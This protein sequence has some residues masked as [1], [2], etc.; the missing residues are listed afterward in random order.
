MVPVSLGDPSGAKGPGDVGVRS[1]VLGLERAV[2]RAGIEEFGGAVDGA[3]AVARAGVQP[4]HRRQ[5]RAEGCVLGGSVVVASAEIGVGAA[6]GGSEAGAG[7]GG[8]GSLGVA[9]SCARKDVTVSVTEVEP[10]A[11]AGHE[12]G[13]KR[14]AADM[15]QV[16]DEGDVV[17][18]FEIVEGS[19]DGGPLAGSVAALEVIAIELP[20][21]DLGVGAVVIRSFDFGVESPLARGL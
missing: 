5:G 13:S 20:R 19:G 6:I 11:R 17:S 18:A 14:D 8:S 16:I 9:Q 1:L 10:V 4:L 2:D 12:H 21:A 15:I 7:R 3:D